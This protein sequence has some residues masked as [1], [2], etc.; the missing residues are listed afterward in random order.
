MPRTHRQALLPRRRP[1]SA[2]AAAPAHLAAAA[3]L[4]LAGRLLGGGGSRF[5]VGGVLSVHGDDG[6]ANRSGTRAGGAVV[7]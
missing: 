1:R 4:A 2:A 5:V 7:R 3:A 6:R